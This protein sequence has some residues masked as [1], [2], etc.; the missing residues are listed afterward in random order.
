MARRASTWSCRA[1]RSVAQLRRELGVADDEQMV[2]I[3]GTWGGLYR[4][5]HYPI[6]LAALVDRPLPGVHLV[7]K[8]HPGEPDEGPYRAIIERAAAA[9][10]VAPP[11]VTTVQSVDLYRLLA[12]ADAHLGI[13]STVL[14]EAVVTRTPNLLADGVAGADLLGY[15]AAR[16]AVP[17]RDGG[18]L[19]AALAADAGRA[20]ARGGRRGV[21]GRPLRAR[22]CQ[23]ADRAPISRRVARMTGPL[24]FLIPARGGSVRVPGKNLRTVGGVPLV[25]SA[26][27]IAR[28][29]AAGPA[30]GPHRIVCST[31]DAGNRDGGARLGCRRPRPAGRSGDRHGDLG[32]RRAPCAGRPGGGSPR[33]HV[34]GG[35]PAPADLAL[36]RSGGS[37]GRGRPVRRLGRPIGG[38]RLGDPSGRLAR[39]PPGRRK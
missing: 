37:R 1:S 17:V 30:G 21:H 24:L 9:R 23:R 26:I 4:R 34:P 7:V 32:R 22:L 27:R 5:F 3:S 25:G 6:A 33:H 18:D 11:R 10:G 35:R 20:P 13:H 2:V 29:A 16:V 15:L 36:H 12:A 28:L 19:L 38:E 14:T 39:H 31:D 8:L